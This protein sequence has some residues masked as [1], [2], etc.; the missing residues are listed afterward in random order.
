MVTLTAYHGRR[1]A[2]RASTRQGSPHRC[3]RDRPLLPGLSRRR[4]PPV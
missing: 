2:S 1:L 3:L 4:K